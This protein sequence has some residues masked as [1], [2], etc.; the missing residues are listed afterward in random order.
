MMKMKKYLGIML[1]VLLLM[2]SVVSCGPK[3]SPAQAPAVTTAAA[4]VTE[5]A[6]AAETPSAP[7]ETKEAETTAGAAETKEA[8]DPLWARGYGDAEVKEGESYTSIGDVSMYY[9]TYGELPPNFITKKQAEKF[10]WQ[11]GDLEPYA[12]GKSIGGGR[13][14]NYEGILPEQK[15]RKYYECDIDTLGKKKRGA[16]RMVYSD[17]GPVIYYTT[18][19]YEHFTLVYGQ[20]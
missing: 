1:T 9:V 16:K 4:A 20:E 11:G 6:K 13:F 17:D 18:D 2:L 5:S 8:K 19:H 15:G 3:E 10:G 14:G 7:E 12:P